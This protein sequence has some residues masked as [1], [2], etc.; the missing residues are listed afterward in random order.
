MDL[1]RLEDI[2][3]TY[4]LG[5]VDVPVLKGITIRGSFTGTREDLEDVFRLAAAGVVR[6]HVEPHALDEAPELFERLRRGE[7]VGRAVINL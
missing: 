3:K 1:I 4:H 7:L 2:Y 5:E 6:P